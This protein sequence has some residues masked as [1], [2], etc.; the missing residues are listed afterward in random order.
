MKATH[1]EV[2]AADSIHK[3]RNLKKLASYDTYYRI[4][5]G[6]YRLGIKIE[7][8]T[9]YSVVLEHRKDVYKGFP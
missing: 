7:N 8:D 4:R 3:I 2:E 6:D 1:F 9:V 5:V